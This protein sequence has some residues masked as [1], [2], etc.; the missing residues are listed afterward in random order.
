MSLTWLL[1]NLLKL[2]LIALIIMISL[3]LSLWLIKH[4]E[5]SADRLLFE[6]SSN[7][8]VDRDLTRLGHTWTLSRLIMHNTSTLQMSSLWCI[9]YSNIR[10]LFFYFFFSGEFK[11]D[12][13]VERI[14]N[15]LGLCF[16]RLLQINSWLSLGG[17]WIFPFN[18]DIWRVFLKPII[19]VKKMKII[20]MSCP[21]DISINVDLESLFENRSNSVLLQSYIL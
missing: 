9:I 18:R 16:R 2:G 20:F 6:H 13:L 5:F 1:F 4:K 7:F 3:R 21:H 8:K 10:L 11:R 19:E 17:R 15:I 12:K 14:L